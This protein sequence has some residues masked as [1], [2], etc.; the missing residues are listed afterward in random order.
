MGGDSSTRENI[1]QNCDSTAWGR[2]GGV[3][4]LR[5]PKVYLWCGVEWGADLSCRLS[6]FLSKGLCFRG[7]S[8]CILPARGPAGRMLGVGLA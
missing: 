8:S 6:G 2:V 1:P 7:S 4:S 5:G 3:Q